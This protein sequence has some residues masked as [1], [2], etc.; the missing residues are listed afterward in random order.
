MGATKVAEFG[1]LFALLKLLTNALGKE[2]YGE[3][4]LAETAMILFTH[5]L[6][7]PIREAYLRNYHGS[8]ERSERRAAGLILIRWY[9]VGTIG[10]AL[11]AVLLSSWVSER[12]GFG[13]QTVLAWGVLFLFDRWRFLAIEALNMRRERRTWALRSIAFQATLVICVAAFLQIGPPAAATALFGYAFASFLFALIVAG[14]M[15]REIVALP[16]GNPSHLG[17]LAVSFGIPFA[18][19]LI[20]QW[21]QGFA[22]RYLLKA[23]LDAETVGLYVAAYQVCGLPYALMLRIGHNL[24]VPI[25]YQRAG[26]LDDATRL[27]SADKLLLVGLGLQ[28]FVGAAM[29]LFYW[30]FGRWLIVALTNETFLVPTAT[31]VA[32]AAGRYVQALAQATQAIFA[33]HRRMTNM[34]W[35]RVFGAAATLGICVPMIEQR[36]AFG[37]ALGSWMALSLY[38]AALWFGP[39]G[40]WR[41][42][43]AA[44]Q[45]ARQALK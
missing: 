11:S 12:F 6:L 28:A 33:V 26:D 15:I 24:L 5:T 40:C 37:A 25:A 8:L 13:R 43:R 19:L 44:R 23:L 3:Y 34:L 30:T 20:L 41:M 17:G 39:S 14:P 22:D 31:V 18:V 38:L 4:N 10:V 32:L 9:A 35:I 29:L 1:I 16:V 36:G 42:V 2:G 45:S 7:A 27:W 21:I